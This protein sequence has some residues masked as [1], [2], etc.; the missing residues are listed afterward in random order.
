MPKNRERH[1]LQPYPINNTIAVTPDDVAFAIAQDS[2][3]CAIVRAVQRQFPDA[4]YV[5]ATT[6]VI[7]WSDEVTDE[8]YVYPTP[9]NAVEQIIK[10]LDTGEEVKPIRITLRNGQV[11]SIDHRENRREIRPRERVRDAAKPPAQRTSTHWS[12]KNYDRFVPGKNGA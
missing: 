6:K 9:V 3:N 12:H 8:R 10:P 4:V 5:R 7:A 1:D 2:Y 11:R